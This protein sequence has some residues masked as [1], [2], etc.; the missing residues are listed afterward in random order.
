[1]TQRRSTMQGCL[2]I[3]ATLYKTF[4]MSSFSSFSSLHCL[5]GYIIDTFVA[6]CAGDDQELNEEDVADYP[7]AGAPLTPV[8]TVA[9]ACACI[10]RVLRCVHSSMSRLLTEDNL[11]LHCLE[12]ARHHLAG[13][14]EAAELQVKPIYHG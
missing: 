2:V 14:D 11:Q 6:D 4:W 5:I 9:A 12:V 3:L 10:D 13:K 1:M 7:M 8:T